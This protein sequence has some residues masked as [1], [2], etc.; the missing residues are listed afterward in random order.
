MVRPVVAVAC[1][2][3]VVWLTEVGNSD[4]GGPWVVGGLVVLGLISLLV[5]LRQLR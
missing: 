5:G 1:V 4:E 3:A 2:L